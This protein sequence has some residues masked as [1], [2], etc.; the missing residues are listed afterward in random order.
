MKRRPDGS[1]TLVDAKKTRLGVGAK[2]RDREE[3]VERIG[4]VVAGYLVHEEIGSGAMGTV[5]R[6]SHLDTNR[7]VA[8]KAMHTHHLSEEKTVERFKR[9]ARIAARLGHPNIGGVIELVRDDKGRYLIALELVEGEPLSGIMTMPLPP[10]RVMLITGQLLRGLEHA[11]AMGL[12][13]RDLKPDN[14]LVEWRNGRDHARIIDFG[15]AITQEGSDDSI[16]RLTAKGHIVGTPVYMAP[17]QAKGEAIDHRADLYSLGVIVYEMIA[18]VVPFEGRP[19]EVLA[20]K[21]KR[22][23][24]SFAD[25]V[26][27]LI[28]DPLLERFCRKLMERNLAERFGSA[29]HALHVLK[30]LQ[31]DPANAGP[32]LG[33]TDVQK[34]LAVVSLP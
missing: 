13:H 1:D 12:V 3:D 15:I 27:N 8:L 29:R 21:L 5:F 26:P 4:T 2:T 18:G 19:I 24:L 17:E 9:E 30:L 22:S 33:V 31:T 6:A 23:P 28:V 10:E 32:A 25:R 34:A 20:A 11:H 14:V 16:E 7:V